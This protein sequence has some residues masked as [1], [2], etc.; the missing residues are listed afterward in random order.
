MD[1]VP[2][3]KR[4][5]RKLNIVVDSVCKTECNNGWMSVLQNDTKP[6]IK[7]L[8]DNS[9]TTLDVM[10][11]KL[12]TSWAV[13]STMTLETRNPQPVWRVSELEHTLF[14][15]ESD[16]PEKHGR[17]DLS[18]GK[19]AGAILHREAARRDARPGVRGNVRVRQSHLP[20]RPRGARRSQ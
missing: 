16:D 5:V 19:L 18:L 17:M 11:C 10:D 15:T 6:L 7:S 1:A 14:Y 12:L 3:I 4:N 8:L 20:G 9:T 13:M 2:R